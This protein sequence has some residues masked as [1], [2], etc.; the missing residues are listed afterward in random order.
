MATITLKNP[1]DKHSDVLLPLL[2]NETIYSLTLNPYQ[3]YKKFDNGVWKKIDMTDDQSK[4]SKEFMDTINSIKKG[5]YTKIFSLI[6]NNTTDSAQSKRLIDAYD[7]YPSIDLMVRTLNF[8]LA[9]TTVALM[10]SDKVIKQPDSD[11][12]LNYLTIGEQALAAP[13]KDSNILGIE[14]VKKN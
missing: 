11:L 14:K 12:I 8:D 1:V 5:G 2:G 3:F 10:L 9:R 13:K 4:N 6:F 7:L